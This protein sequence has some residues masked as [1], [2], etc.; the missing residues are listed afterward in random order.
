M[1]LCLPRTTSSPSGLHYSIWKALAREN[2]I[3]KW[4]AIMMSLPFMHGFTHRR[5][6]K[7]VDVM[8]E[9]KKGVRKIH[10]LRIIGILEADF[11][12]ALKILFARRLMAMAETTGMHDEQWGSRGN[13]TS[14][15]AALRKMMTFEYGRYMNAT[16]ALF[17]NDQTACFDRMWPGLTNVVAAAYGAGHQALE[18]R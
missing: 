15:D 11:N 14:T 18:C 7:M 4:L 2:D 10:Q 6:T 3:A 17:A 1:S 12:T 13:R 16:I 5:W 9:K 8:L